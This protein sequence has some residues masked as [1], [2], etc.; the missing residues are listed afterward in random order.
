[1]IPSAEVKTT[2]LKHATGNSEFYNLNFFRLIQVVKD[3]EIKVMINESLPI[4]DLRVPP[5]QTDPNA[6][7]DENAQNVEAKILDRTSNTA[8]IIYKPR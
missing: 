1:M 8:T 6:I 5:F 2:V 3:F 7:T 4:K